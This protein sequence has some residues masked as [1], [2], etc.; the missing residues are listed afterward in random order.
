[1]TALGK[2]FRT[3]AIKL[4]VMYLGVLTA[5]SAVLLV[6][7]SQQT[8]SVMRDQIVET[9]DA[10]ITGLSDQY[11]IGGIRRL[12]AAVDARSRQPG[13]SLYLVTD[14]AG[15]SLAGNIQ[16]LSSSVLA[17]AD[18]QIQRVRYTRF[19]NEKSYE[20]LVRVFG[21]TGG[22]RILVGRDLAEQQYFRG[23]LAE[24]LRYWLIVVVLLGLLTWVFV[25]RRVLKRIDAMAATSRRIMK[26]DLNERLPV[27]GSGDEFDRL[28][29][30]LN[31][32]LERIEAL[33]YGLKDVS[34]NIAHDLKTPLTR[35]RNRVESA[36]RESADEDGA[37][38]R[39][40]LE[41][42][43]EDCDYLIRTFNA[44]LRI[45]RVEA[46]SSDAEMHDVDL[47]ALAG[48]IAE[49]YEPLA[50]DE[51]AT[52]ALG[53]L[54]GLTVRGNR[55]LL[56]QALVNL[57]ENALKYGKDQETGIASITIGMEEDNGEACL[58]VKDKGSGIAEA[59]RDRAARR[60]VRLETS[61]S[62]PGS[63][64]GLS[65][66]QAVTR[67]HHGKLELIDGEP[68]LKA[69]LRLPLKD[70]VSGVKEDEG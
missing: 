42:T 23:V 12:V 10:E 36:L 52:L 69:V 44:L 28:A 70:G 4:A 25:S 13:A 33:L 43:I 37:G 8:A 55:E 66:V 60:F 47:K 63:G 65:L 56:A 57:T 20:A 3:T 27:D 40:A 58:Y 34:D 50:E 18:G 62:E 14:F 39:Q 48:E 22:Y 24:S 32:M 54:Q 29:T 15:N 41:A 26:G 67:L 49:L 46:G 7:V 51:G 64:L 6:Y 38:A 61:R 21:L 30:S 5:A 2:L 53:P 45:A 59:D 31:E 9:V 35:M 68:G 16:Q 17:E 1:M 19:E 11:R